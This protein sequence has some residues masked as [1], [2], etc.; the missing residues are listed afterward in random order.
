LGKGCE[1]FFYQSG[2]QSLRDGRPAQPFRGLITNIRSEFFNI[3]YRTANPWRFIDDELTE[4]EMKD[5]ADL[6]RCNLKKGDKVAKLDE[7]S[8]M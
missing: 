7:Y 1:F 3:A 6:P 8:K 5:D 2:S 4:F